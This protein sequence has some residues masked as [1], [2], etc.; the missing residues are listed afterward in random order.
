MRLDLITHLIKEIFLLTQ[1][2]K[3]TNLRYISCNETWHGI[4]G[5]L[6][7]GETRDHLS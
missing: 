1:L 6:L 5:D 4:I 7:Y 2:E 3:F